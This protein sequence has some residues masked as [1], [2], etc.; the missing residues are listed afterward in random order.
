MGGINLNLNKLTESMSS[1]IGHYDSERVAYNGW[2][3]LLFQCSS[4]VESVF[5]A[6]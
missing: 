5:N 6:I 1:V 2:V 4:R 3:S